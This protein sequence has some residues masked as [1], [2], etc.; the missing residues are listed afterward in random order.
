ML[1]S[2]EP[3]QLSALFEQAKGALADIDVTVR[4]ANTAV[5][6]ANGLLTSVGRQPQCRSRNSENYVGECG[7][8][9][10]VAGLKG[11]QRNSRNVSE[12]PYGTG[13]WVRLS[14]DNA[15]KATSDV[16]KAAANASAVVDDI[17]SREFRASSM[18]RWDM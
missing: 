9:T 7:T 6:T 3:L 18:R 15:E 10:V 11:G 5:T 1:A 17:R 16:Q 12:R 4:N 8:T 13:R 14:V 2:K